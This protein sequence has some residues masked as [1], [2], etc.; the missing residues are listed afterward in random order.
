MER[1]IPPR[2]LTGAVY[3]AFTSLS[4]FLARNLVPTGSITAFGGTTA[5]TGWLLCDGSSVSRAD[6]PALFT[7][8]GTVWGS[9]SGT[10]FNV[11]DLRG[12]TPIGAGS[13]VGLTTRSLASSGGEETHLLTSG[14]MP[15]HSHTQIVTANTGGG[16][17][18]RS[19]Y[20]L[21]VVNGGSF[22]Q[23]VSTGATGGGAAHNVM[24]P[25]RAV[26]YIIRA[27]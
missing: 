8:I 20:D 7:A 9:G 11:P 3:Q 24:Q 12:R 6:Y 1:F 4:K 27:T 13:G 26:N 22:P 2:N 15:S 21:D 14:E 10:T 23:G 19:D 25:W 16:T 18:V 5:P 17:A